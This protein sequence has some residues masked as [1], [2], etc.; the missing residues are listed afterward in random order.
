M[1]HTFVLV[2]DFIE[3]NIVM[4]ILNQLVKFLLYLLALLFTN[5]TL[6]MELCHLFM[7][8]SYG[9]MLHQNS[10]NHCHMMYHQ[11]EL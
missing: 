11:Q 5:S 1:F 4:I 10:Q 7:I 2:T 9:D 8:I 6:W 3:D